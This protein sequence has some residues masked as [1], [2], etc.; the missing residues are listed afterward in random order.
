MSQPAESGSGMSQEWKISDSERV[1]AGLLD[2]GRPGGL[3]SR[4]DGRNELPTKNRS[5]FKKV[6][7]NP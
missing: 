5:T 1:W 4:I 2:S 7:K 6:F 3:W